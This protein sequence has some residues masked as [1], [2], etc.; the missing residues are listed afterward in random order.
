MP[1]VNGPVRDPWDEEPP[2]RHKEPP[3][4]RALR[5]ALTGDKALQAFTRVFKR[6]PRSEAELEQ[7]IENYTRELYNE[8]CDGC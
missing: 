1:I 3:A 2:R 5:R 6:P 4:L 8:G 7:F